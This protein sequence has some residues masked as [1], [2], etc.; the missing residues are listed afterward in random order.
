M[1]KILITLIVL[2]LILAALALNQFLIITYMNSQQHQNNIL[3]SYLMANYGVSSIEELIEKKLEEYGLRYTGNPFTTALYPGQFQAENIT[4]MH[5]Y[6][7][8]NSDLQNRTDV[9]AYPSQ[10]A[11]FIVENVSGTIIWKDGTN[12]TVYATGTT[13]TEASNIINWALGN[14]TSGRTWQEKVVLKGNFA[15]KSTII[16]PSYTFLDLYDAKLTLA[17]DVD[18]FTVENDAWWVTFAG[19]HL[20]GDKNNRAAGNGIVVPGG[21]YHAYRMRIQDMRIEK[22]KEDGLR[23]GRFTLGWIVRCEIRENDGSGI[24]VVN[25]MDNG[26]SI[27]N[28]VSFNGEYGLY[29]ESTMGFMDVCSLYSGNRKDGV[30]FGGTESQFIGTRSEDNNYALANYKNFYVRQDHNQFIGC[31]SRSEGEPKP[32]R[33]YEEFSQTHPNLLVGCRFHGSTDGIAPFNDTEITGVVIHRYSGGAWVRDYPFTK[34]I[35]IPASEGYVMSG[36]LTY[37]GQYAVVR[38]DANAAEPAVLFSLRI[39]D[40]FRAFS[41]LKA[42]WTSPASSGNARWRFAVHYAGAGEVY[43]NTSEDLSM[44]QTATGGADILNVQEPANSLTLT[45]LTAGDYIGINFWRDGANAADTLD[46]YFYLVGIVFE[47]KSDQP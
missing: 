33:D 27:L 28:T 11:R 38:G 14:L 17:A 25:D 39:P 40:D 36:T 5:W 22:F 35:F 29:V 23:L 13:P 46:D 10:P 30:W 34:R 12:G 3:K 43:N 4:G 37:R 6:T 21:D 47:Y 16:V 26:R 2:N 24:H 42:V 18:M 20:D 31:R 41:S 45:N 19:G 1:K 15:V 32:Y 44:G 9:I 8:L 7:Y